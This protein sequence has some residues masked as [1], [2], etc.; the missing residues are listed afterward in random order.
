[1]ID[2]ATGGGD[3]PRGTVLVTRNPSPDLVPLLPS[4][5]A[6]IS[7]SGS[8]AG[9]LA[10]LA[11]EHRVPA[12]MATEVATNVLQPG[13]EVTVD[14]DENVVYAGRVEPPIRYGL[15]RADT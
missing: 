7:D 1:M 8:P 11:R 6:L 5:V 14:A 2:P 13:T 9:H 4:A 15:W 12:G 3:A 10:A